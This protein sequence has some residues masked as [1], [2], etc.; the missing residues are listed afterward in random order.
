M[1]SIDFA[2]YRYTPSIAAAS[3][4]AA[5][6][7]VITIFHC[8]RLW[9]CRAYFFIPFIIGVLCANSPHSEWERIR[10]HMED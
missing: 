2:L 3:I 8:I 7:L 10:I 1:S 5:V 6:F 9:R 4:F